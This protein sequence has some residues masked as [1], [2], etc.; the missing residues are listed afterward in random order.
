M[1]QYL[2]PC[3]VLAAA[4]TSGPSEEE[5]NQIF[6]TTNSALSNGQS[7]ALA[8]TD[9]SGNLALDY[10]GPCALGGTLSLVGNFN[11]DDFD[12]A[13]FDLT[14]SFTACKDAGGT[15]DGELQWTAEASAAG[16]TVSLVGDV[17]WDNGSSS[18]SCAIDLHMAG[19]MTSV[20]YSGTICGYSA[21]A[22]LM[23]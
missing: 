22:Q 13:V 1:K 18:A 15:L 19:S 5:A 3:L 20:S 7:A 10:T 9:G 23:F 11:D 14:A 17:D 6:A 12:Q 4:C 2:L 21:S 8:Q 16:A